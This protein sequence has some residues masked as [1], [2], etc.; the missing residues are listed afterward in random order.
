MISDIKSIRTNIAETFK[1]FLRRDGLLLL[2]SILI[3]ILLSASFSEAA[4]VE[5]S[6]P[7]TKI[8]LLGGLCGTALSYSRFKSTFPLIFTTLLSTV[9]AVQGTWRVMLP[10]V[11]AKSLTW[12]E[13]L[14]LTHLRLLNALNQIGYW[15]NSLLRE[16]E[17]KDTK[18]VGF[19]LMIL[20]W[21]ACVWMLWNFIRR[22]TALR[23]LI[24]TAL[25]LTINVYRYAVNIDI[26]H[27]FLF[28]AIL[29]TAERS[30]WGQRHEWDTR[31]VPYPYELGEWPI[32][33]IFIAIL[34]GLAMK[35]APLVGTEKGWESIADLFRQPQQEEIVY[36]Y[37]GAENPF[38]FETGLQPAGVHVGIGI[39]EMGT[40]GAPP[41][42]LDTT[43]MWVAVDKFMGE[44]S[45]FSAAQGG[46]AGHF[47]LRGEIFTAYTGTGWD[48]AELRPGI[49]D[50]ELEFL[51][52]PSGSYRAIEQRIF[53]LAEHDDILFALNTP[54]LPGVGTS[55]YFTE[56]DASTLLRGTVESFDVTSW[57]PVTTAALLILASN[58]YPSPI[59]ETYLQLPDSIP[60]RV[61]E[62]AAHITAG[63]DTSFEK[64]LRIQDYLRQVYPYSTEVPPVPLERDIVDYFL[65]EAPGGGFCSYYAS[66]MVVMLRSEG[67]PAR[68]VTG[69]FVS[70][71]EPEQGAYR[72]PAS[73]AHAWVEVYFPGHGWLEF[74]P[75]PIRQLPLFE[76]ETA[77]VFKEPLEPQ[78]ANPFR[79]VNTLSKILPG[80]L[81]LLAVGLFAF[82]GRRLMRY[83]F[84]SGS[85]AENLYWQMRQALVW[86]DL[87]GVKSTTPLEFLS[88]T[89]T[90]A[91]QGYPRLYV[92]VLKI[93]ENY[94]R[95]TFSP[96]YPAKDETQ[97]V[98]K[99]WRAAFPEWSKLWAATS[100]RNSKYLWQKRLRNK[101]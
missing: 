40:I 61:R 47:Y 101:R 28:A 87:S 77:V 96:H 23:G 3:L 64:A 67:I 52:T 83:W 45:E 43:V 32:S 68:L 100:I 36:I 18:A 90:E 20:T 56:P 95:A 88:E 93:T 46:S 73:A 11:I 31:R 10:S 76:H 79:W 81:L 53:I 85:R 6:T 51:S 8:I 63:A 69:F 70:E 26:F 2:L 92:A 7:L 72:V 15:F 55:L 65:F 42:Q 60:Q 29:L 22:R 91:L 97:A 16:G 59:Q 41:S 19:L 62:M 89:C 66:A 86:T 35:I 37:T 21:N 33:A 30:F 75:T 4:R 99:L 50:I 27:I 44:G 78:G 17:I 39:S 98:Q 5:D 94:L 14:A 84:F 24:P 58:R 54:A 82:L 71:Y 34:I 57:K 38:S 13:Y 80:I 74:E 9:S 49:G 1:A 25:L 48:R 12:P